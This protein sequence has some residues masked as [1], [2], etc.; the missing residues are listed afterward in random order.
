MW[1]VG[2]WLIIV[3]IGYE[4]FDGVVWEEGFEFV[5]ELGCKGFVGC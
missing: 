5:V 1:D 2:F 4:I 3:V